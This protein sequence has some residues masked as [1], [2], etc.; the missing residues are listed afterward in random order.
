MGTWIYR[1][2]CFNNYRH[3]ISFKVKMDWVVNYVKTQT[4]NVEGKTI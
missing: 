1:T 3:R 4:N 2:F